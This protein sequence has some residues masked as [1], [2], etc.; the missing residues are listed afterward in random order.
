MFMSIPKTL[1][2]LIPATFKNRIKAIFPRWNKST[3]NLAG[4]RHIE[5]SFI[6]ANCPN[7]PG[8]ALDFGNGGSPLCLLAAEKGFQVT[9][10]DLNDVHWDF[11]DPRIAFIKGDILSLPLA[12]N[13]Y[14]CVINCSAIE[15]VGLA[16]RYGVST[17]KPDGDVEAMKRLLRSLKPGGVMLL[18]VPVGQDAVFAPLARVYGEKRLPLLL[19][20]FTVSKEEYWLKDQANKWL[21][22]S[23]REALAFKASVR[24]ASPLGNIYALGCF[25]LQKKIIS[26]RNLVSGTHDI[27]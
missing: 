19:D 24:S 13:T 23:R 5:W 7:G 3:A 12:A 15:H 8:Q 11:R 17:D 21:A 6:S 18:T 27:E 16:G 1:R 10:V 22:C 26:G 9:A 25:V 20:L 14:D 4:D 2:K